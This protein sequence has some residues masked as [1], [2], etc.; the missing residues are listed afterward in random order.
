MLSLNNKVYIQLKTYMLERFNIKVEEFST[1]NFLENCTLKGI[2]A[3]DVD[4]GIMLID[5]AKNFQKHGKCKVYR[6]KRSRT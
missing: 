2:I 6:N 5:E 4:D 1:A 3:H